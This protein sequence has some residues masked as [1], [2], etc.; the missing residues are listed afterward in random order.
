LAEHAM[1]AEFQV[2]LCNGTWFL[3]PFHSSM[4]VVGSRWVYK[5]KCCADGSI[6]CYIAHLIAR[7]FT[8][9]KSIDDS[10]TFSLMV[11]QAIVQLVLIII[12]SWN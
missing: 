1:E 10:K 8:H 3:V 5:I 11:K 4:N 2:L 6:E 9:Q 12:V 7:G